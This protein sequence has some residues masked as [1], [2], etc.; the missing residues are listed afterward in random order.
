MITNKGAFL[1]IKTRYKSTCIEQQES[2][3]K[4]TTPVWK[5]ISNIE[6]IVTS[7]P[8]QS[9]FQSPKINIDFTAVIEIGFASFLQ[10]DSATPGGMQEQ[11]QFYCP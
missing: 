6:I 4:W 10:F 1:H 7:I 5:L 2:A 3:G 8:K 11:I 9:I